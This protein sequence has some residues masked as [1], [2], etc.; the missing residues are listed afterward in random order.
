MID[1]NELLTLLVDM[2]SFRVE[3]TVSTTDTQKFCE[4]ICA[5]ANDM[6]GSKLPGFLLI[7]VDDK[8]GEPTG[9]TVTDQLLQNLSGLA[10]DG[11]L[12]PPPAIMAYRI[13]LSSGKGEV[14]VVK[15]QPSEIPPVRYKGVVRIRRGPRKGIAN[16]SE[17]RI[18]A[19]RRTAFHLSYD[20]QPCTGST[21]SDMAL[22]LFTTGSSGRGRR[23]R[24]MGRQRR[25]SSLAIPSSE[26]PSGQIY[27]NHCVFQ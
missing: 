10:A 19:E 27:E 1:E 12:L 14:A 9:L 3:R 8:T 21:L 16:E 15:V 5:F 26:S 6:A 11:N 20:A 2:E 22:D 17:E 4:A 7:R 25:N 13:A 23:S 24:P 18:L